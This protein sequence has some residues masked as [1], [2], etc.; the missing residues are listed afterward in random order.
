VQKLFQS[1][2]NVW[3]SQLLNYAIALKDKF[4]KALLCNNHKNVE[5]FLLT[6]G[7]WVI[8]GSYFWLSVFSNPH[9]Q[10]GGGF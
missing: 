8:S 7:M 9:R 2:I 3:N 1:L 5:K 6:C 10:I 4:P